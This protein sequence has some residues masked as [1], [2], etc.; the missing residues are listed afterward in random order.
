M[1]GHVTISVELELGWGLHDVD[2]LDALSSGRR[3][4]SAYLTRLLDT[5]DALQ[6]PVS[7]DIVG[8]LFREGP[9]DVYDGPHPGGWFDIVRDT[10]DDPD[11][12]FHAPDLVEAIKEAEVGHEICTHTFSH[13]ECRNVSPET[14]R[15]ELRRVCEE[16]EQAGLDVPR[17]FVP[18]RHSLP[19]YECLRE[20]GIETIRV[21]AD[22]HPAFEE[23][24]GRVQKA[25]APMIGTPPATDP[26]L[27]DGL[28]ESYTTGHL[29][30]T[31]PLLPSGQQTPHPVFR[32]L[33][34]SL[35]KRLHRR[36]LR[37]ALNAAEDTGSSVH[38]WTHVWDLANDAQWPQVQAF[39]QELARRRD[40]GRLSTATMAN[41]G[42]SVRSLQ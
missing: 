29:S 12:R 19:E 11:P 35:R 4:E 13:V 14:V 18:P 40:Q 9:L 15:W 33:P 37:R 36:Y 10:H 7:F 2:G 25:L 17:S 27:V 20:M 31:T 1:P 16:H 6:L 42:E 8:H 3:Q 21:P 22:R 39:L 34:E 30:L 32:S 5:C 26:R 41:L 23:P 24:S 38:L 28:V